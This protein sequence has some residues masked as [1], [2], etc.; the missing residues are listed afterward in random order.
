MKRPRKTRRAKPRPEPYELPDTTD[1]ASVDAAEI[2][3]IR[4]AARHRMTSL[5][6]LRFTRMLD[7]RRRVIADRELE[8]AIEDLRQDRKPSG[9]RRP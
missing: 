1:L 9:E 4:L 2:E 7:H 8:Q 3:I 5:E 6:A